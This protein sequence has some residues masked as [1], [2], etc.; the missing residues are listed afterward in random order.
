MSG[1]ENIAWLRRPR[2]E[3]GRALPSTSDHVAKQVTRVSL[4]DGTTLAIHTVTTSKES[5][6]ERQRRARLVVRLEIVLAERIVEIAAKRFVRLVA[7]SLEYH[8]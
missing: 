4:P 8:E 6:L 5:E 1:H 7:T 2:D 3:R